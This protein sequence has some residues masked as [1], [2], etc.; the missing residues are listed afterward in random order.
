MR[1]LLATATLAVEYVRMLALLPS[2]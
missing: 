2:K 1:P